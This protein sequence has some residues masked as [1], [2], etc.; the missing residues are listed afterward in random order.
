MTS[1]DH[2]S[3][4]LYYSIYTHVWLHSYTTLLH[5]IDKTTNSICV[6]VSNL[7][8]IQSFHYQKIRIFTN[9]IFQLYSALISATAYTIL[10]SERLN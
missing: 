8:L 5:I 6:G 3:Y 9:A 10:V 7:L 2:I 4:I 1:Y